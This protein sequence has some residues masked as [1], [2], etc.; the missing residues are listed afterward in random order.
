MEALFFCP[1]IWRV[2]RKVLFLAIN[3]N[4]MKQL[5]ADA[6]AYYK[7]AASKSTA[8]YGVRFHLFNLE[9]A[10]DNLERAI[11]EEGHE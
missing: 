1:I 5:K 9:C 6:L 11:K 2:E 10:L 3:F 4:L 7:W 8:P